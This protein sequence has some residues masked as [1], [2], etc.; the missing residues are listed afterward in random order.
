MKTS[1]RRDICFAAAALCV[2][3]AD[4]PCLP[5]APRLPEPAP[6]GELRFCLRA[7]PKTFNPLLISGEPD[8]IVAYL[9]S[10]VLIRMNRQTQAFEAE[11][12]DSWRIS[13]K[14]R[15]IEFH[16]REG[17]RF[18]DGSALTPEDVLFTFRTLLD[19]ATLSPAGDT[20]RAMK[21]PIQVAAPGKQ[22]I[23]FSFREP[24]AGV[25]RLFDQAPIVSAATIQKSRNPAEMPV[26]GPY[27]ISEY[28]PGASLVLAR[29]PYYW[30]TEATGRRLPYIDSIRLSVQQNR[31]L[32]CIRFL[33]GEIDLIN[34]LDA[35]S[36]ERLAARRAAE[37]LD[38]GRSLEGEQMWFNQTARA[39]I[40][41]YRKEWFRSREFRRAISEAI[42]RADL[43]R[44]IYRGRAA[45]A[46]GPVSPANRFW[47]N[48]KL[49][50]P[51][52]SPEAALARL[53]QNGFHMDGVALRDRDG[54]AVEFSVVTNSGNKSREQ[55]AAMIQQDLA[56]IGIRLNVVTLDF[57]SLIERITGTFAYESCL[58]GLVNV[59]LDPCGQM[60]V[61]LSSGSNHPWN[62]AQPAPETEWEAAIDRLMRA[63]AGEASLS[64]RKAL[65]DRV[66]EIIVSQAPALYLVDK[67][68][69][70]AVSSA[71][72]NV[73][74]AVLHP[75]TFWNIER[76]YF[77][78]VPQGTAR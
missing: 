62:P 54:H 29:N 33:R 53:K 7:E 5:G 18:S 45:P 77:K 23:T 59:D 32:E 38:A 49:Q 60:N 71:L 47:C 76:L 52:Y 20:F 41:P 50:P 40:P 36:F 58:L 6:G 28:R 4:A 64:R 2:L 72:G 26:L 70:S 31:D 55:M 43:A 51:V 12:A 63:Q 66:Q 14:G 27:R 17:V 22:R 56:R 21:G 37:A 69:L 11:L 25:E 57:G 35:E 65:F 13:D 24:V 42:N 19:P 34:S 73:S 8:E 39:P 9:T 46:V 44:V 68:A 1:A 3:L 74:P 61:W 75:Q 48:A 16:L 30:K 67:N 78:T 10:G 15:T